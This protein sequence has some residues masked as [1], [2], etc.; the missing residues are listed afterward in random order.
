MSQPKLIKAEEREQLAPLLNI[1]SAGDAA[2]AY[3]ALSHPAE[4]VQIYVSYSAS[5]SPI[6]FL[7]LA[8]TGLDLFRPLAVPFVASAAILHDLIQEAIAPNEQVI[9]LL[10]LDQREW[11]EAHLALSDI[12][13]GELF[14]LDW[15]TFKPIINILVMEVHNPDG[16]P[17]Y[18]VH[19]R[20]GAYA[21]AGVNW[22]GNPYAEIYLEANEEA[23]GRDL[24]ISVLAAMSGRLLE[25]G[26]TPLFRLDNTLI[27]SPESLGQVGYRSTGTRTLIAY[28]TRNIK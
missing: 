12:R 8:R 17:R 18:E 6:G 1:K 23:Q 9:L 22:I 2:A 16:L 11:I 27:L 28:A 13:I 4:R 10:P 14:R 26:R 25:M 19:S 5:G 3:Y 20:T 7:T 21:A 15:A 24:A